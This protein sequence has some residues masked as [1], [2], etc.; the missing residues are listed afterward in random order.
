MKNSPPLNK[1]LKQ[2]LMY[3]NRTIS[4]IVLL[5]MHSIQVMKKILN[6]HKSET[7]QTRSST[8]IQHK[9]PK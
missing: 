6:A 2:N 7:C 8:K 4:S 1:T 3:L 9:K 5:K